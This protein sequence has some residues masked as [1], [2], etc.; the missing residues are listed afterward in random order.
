MEKQLKCVLLLSLK[1]MAVVLWN[2]SDILVSISK[3]RLYGFNTEKIKLCWTTAGTIDCRK[4]AEELVCCDELNVL[5]RYAISCS[6]C[7]FAYIPLFWEELPEDDKELLYEETPTCPAL[8]FCWLHTLKGEQTKLDH[9]LRTEDGNLTTFNQWAF[10][11]SVENGNKTAAEYF[12]LKLTHEEREAS[13]IRTTHSV[14]A[15]TK[16]RILLEKI[17]SDLLC[18]LLSLMTPEQQMETIETRPIDVLLC[19]FYLS[20]QD[21]F[22][23]NAGL[24]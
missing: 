17:F 6:Y 1:E 10:E 22:M 5:H 24:I 11:D 18:Y 20:W 16:L 19:F 8:H 14:L 23:E 4:T 12:F 21:L 3:F 13:L 7:L 2:D 9:L 15:N